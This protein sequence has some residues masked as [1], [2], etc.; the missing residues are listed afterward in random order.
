MHAICDRCLILHRGVDL[1]CHNS[2][3][4]GPPKINY[5]TIH[6]HKKQHTESQWSYLETIVPWL[7]TQSEFSSMMN[8]FSIHHPGDISIA[9]FLWCFWG[10]SRNKR[11]ALNLQ[12]YVQSQ[13]GA[14]FE[15][16]RGWRCRE[17]GRCR[18]RGATSCLWSSICIKSAWDWFGVLHSCKW[19]H[20]QWQTS[21]SSAFERAAHGIECFWFLARRWR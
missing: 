1:W 12:N 3:F 21:Q 15:W 20:G 18:Y 2:V 4:P 8:F 9:L 14:G 10:I 11:R 17:Q 13:L 5:S 6:L 16:W 19:S 7:I